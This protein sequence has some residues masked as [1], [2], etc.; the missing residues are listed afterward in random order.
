[1]PYDHE[2]QAF[3]MNACEVSTNVVGPDCAQSLLSPVGGRVGFSLQPV[4]PDL[5]FAGGVTGVE[6][7]A[8][9]LATQ[10]ALR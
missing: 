6:R 7:R 2:D 10:P 9:P 3:A 8:N 5:L 1:M 4:N